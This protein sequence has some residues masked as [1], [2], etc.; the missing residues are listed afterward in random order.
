[1]MDRN[2]RV[3][4]EQPKGRRQKLRYQKLSEEIADV[5]QEMIVNGELESGQKVTQEELAASLGVSTMPI[6][7]ALLKLA[8]VGLVDAAPNRSFHVVS[9]TPADMHDSYWLHAILEGELTRRACVNRGPDLAPE[10]RAQEQAYESAAAAQDESA[11]RHSNTAFHRIIN[12]AAN[13]PRLL[14][15]LKTTLR[16]AR[17]GW[18]PRIEG[19]VAQSIEAHAKIIDAF[20]RNDANAAGQAAQEH[21]L[22]AGKLL[23]EYFE[24]TGQWA[25]GSAPSSTGQ[26]ADQLPKLT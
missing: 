16:F 4:T 3:M 21:V 6:R 5:L 20:E 1:V 19:W 15:L 18:Y 13:A 24:T 17:E 25:R 11:L 10:L 23:V 9:T 26:E 22:D 2:T 14:F 7:E 12:K 8:A